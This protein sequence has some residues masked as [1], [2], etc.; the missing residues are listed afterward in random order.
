MPDRDFDDE[1]KEILNRDPLA[2][3]E[4]GTHKQP[5]PI[6]DLPPVNPDGLDDKDGF[7]VGRYNAPPQEI[8]AHA[9]KVNALK[10]AAMVVTG[11][12]TFS[13]TIDTYLAIA[14]GVGFKVVLELPFT[15][16][17]SYDEQPRDEKL[18][19]LWRADGILLVFDT[20]EKDVNGGNFYYNWLAHQYGDR[21]GATSSGSYI[22]PPGK[23]WSEVE[24][25]NLVWAGSHDCREGL[26]FHIRQLEKYGKFLPKWEGKPFLWLLHH[27]DHAND[28]PYDYEAINK[29]RIAMLPPEVQE[30]IKC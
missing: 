12:T 13:N 3:V 6:L 22:L 14:K 26:K 1:I 18:F 4:Q 5:D 9:F 7:D 11:D 23:K 20:F 25:T 27:G 10:R 17:Q 24:M 21:H 28:K 15:V 2:E 19:V 30:A 16:K 8:L 29:E